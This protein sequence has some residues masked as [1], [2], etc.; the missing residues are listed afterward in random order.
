LVVEPVDTFSYLRWTR[1]RPRN[2][3][4]ANHFL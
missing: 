3:S 4:K 2:C 1:V